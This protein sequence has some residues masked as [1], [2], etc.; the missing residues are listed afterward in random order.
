MRSPVWIAWRCRKIHRLLCSLRDELVAVRPDLRLTLTLWSEPYLPQL[1]GSGK[2][3]NQ[4]HA[5]PSTLEFYRE[6][7]F[8]PALCRDE[9]NIEADLQF[10]GGGR[11]RSANNLDNAPMEYGFMFR[12]HDFLDQDTL[13]AWHG[14]ARP[15]AFIFNAWHEAWGKHRWF[16]C[17]ADDPHKNDL[18]VMSGQPAEGIFRVNSEYPR[19]GFWFDS[20]LRITHAF[21]PE[22]H[23]LEQYAHAVAELDACRIT[24]GGLFLD[25]AHSEELRGFAAA[26]RNLPAQRFETVGAST[27]PVAVRTLVPRGEA[28]RYIYLVNRAY[29]PVTVRVSLDRPAELVN[30]ADE[31]AVSAPA[32]WILALQP[33]ELYSFTADPAA[34]VTGFAVDVPAEIAAGL[35]RETANALEAIA[36]AR[37]TGHCIAGLDRI[38]SDLRRCLEERCFSRLQHL[39]RGYHVCKCHAL[40]ACGPE[41]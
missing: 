33:Y 25:K 27:D 32:E 5:R 7:G 2:P 34:V 31:S 30:L 21:P 16:P 14:L 26:Y 35:R 12:D 19:D 18:A 15:G 11:D 39:L 17:D 24:R 23:F 29:Y 4:L 1:I 8:D 20:Q 9:P 36:A 3:G 40:M 22:R 6:A 41:S 37:R 28:R 13:D 38:E 10:E